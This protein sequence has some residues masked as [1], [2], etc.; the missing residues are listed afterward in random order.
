MAGFP[1]T[2][3]G[4]AD[5]K[6]EYNF[7]WKLGLSKTLKQKSYKHIDFNAEKGGL[8]KTLFDNSFID[9]ICQLCEKV[10]IPDDEFEM[11]ELDYGPTTVKIPKRVQMHDITVTYL[12]DS[13]NSVYNFHKAW[14]KTIRHGGG[15]NT[16]YLYSAQATYTIFDRTLTATEQ[17]ALRNI[18]DKY[19][20]SGLSAIVT[21]NAGLSALTSML[22]DE[23]DP[24]THVTGSQIYPFIYPTKVSGRSG[25]KSSTELS[26]TEVTYAR[27]PNI[28]P[29][30]T[31]TE[32]NPIT[33]GTGSVTET[34]ESVTEIAGE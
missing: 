10:N 4:K 29:P 26:R 7:I 30:K 24:L 13:L 11:E 8:A 18:G 33:E 25:D 2:I 22:G 16:P 31:S 14:I 6:K 15:I 5:F 21:S 23:L 9:Y 28:I 1:Y 17:L 20:N 3:P 19:L 32:T 27:L 34:V 12:E